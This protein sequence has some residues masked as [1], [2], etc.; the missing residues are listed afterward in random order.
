MTLFFVVLLVVAAVL[1]L[2]LVGTI[3]GFLIMLLVAALIGAAADALVP[4]RLPYGWVGAMAAGLLGAWLGTLLM[5]RIPPVIA[6]LPL[7]P[8]VAGAVLVAFVMQYALK[9][10]GAASADRTDIVVRR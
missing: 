5:G 4:G 9:S 7:I 8:A 1:L 6:G 2:K 10:G 3:L